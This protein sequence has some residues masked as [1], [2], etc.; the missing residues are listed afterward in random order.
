MQA[1]M[2]I[3]NVEPLSNSELDAISGYLRERAIR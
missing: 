3:S 2:A 1:I